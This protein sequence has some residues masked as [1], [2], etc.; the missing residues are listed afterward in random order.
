MKRKVT[1]LFTPILGLA[2]GM[3]LLLSPVGAWQGQ[4]KGQGQGRGNQGNGNGN[5]GNNGNGACHRRATQ[6]LQDCMARADDASD[7][8]QCVARFQDRQERCNSDNGG[9]DDDDD[10]E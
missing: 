6:R 1:Y 9:N 2:L 5:N 7:R 3:L 10:T 8:Q 4:G